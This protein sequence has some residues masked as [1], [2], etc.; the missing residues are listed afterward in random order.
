MEIDIDQLHLGLGVLRLMAHVLLEGQ[1][2]AVISLDPQV[3][4]GEYAIWV[5]P[6]G[7]ELRLGVQEDDLP[8]NIAG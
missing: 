4:I 1:L 6:I 5:G 3:Q 8:L 2:G 7:R